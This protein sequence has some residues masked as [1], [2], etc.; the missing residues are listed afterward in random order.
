MEYKSQ[1]TLLMQPRSR[2]PRVKQSFR[3]VAKWFFTDDVFRK[4]QEVHARRD[5]SLESMDDNVVYDWTDLFHPEMIRFLR[6]W[7]V[8]LCMAILVMVLYISFSFLIHWLTGEKR[9]ERGHRI[10]PSAIDKARFDQHIKDFE[11]LCGV[12][13]KR[14]KDVNETCALSGA[15][16]GQYKAMIYFSPSANESVLMLNPSV[17]PIEPAYFKDAKFTPSLICRHVDPI[18]RHYA[19]AVN[20]TYQILVQRKLVHAHRELK[21]RDATCIQHAQDIVEGKWPCIDD[22]MFVDDI[23]QVP[24][25][26]TANLHVNL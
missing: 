3:F 19:V 17:V 8:L 1:Q 23:R 14:K 10:F 24:L 9:F 11:T 16:I 7:R 20:V 2:A 12:Y 5:I 18:K 21:G 22:S 6:V 15:H 13:R 25:F 4:I 26:V